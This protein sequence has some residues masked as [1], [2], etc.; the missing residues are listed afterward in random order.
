[1]VG[2]VGGVM[3]APGTRNSP[4]TD[5]RTDTVTHREGKGGGRANV[6]TQGGVQT[7]TVTHREREG[8]GKSDIVTLR[9]GKDGPGPAMVS[10]PLCPAVHILG[11]KNVHSRAKGTY[12]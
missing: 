3:V 1:M 2:H 11:T 12:Y 8:G 7:E 10:D 4:Q 6:V 9:K 5:G